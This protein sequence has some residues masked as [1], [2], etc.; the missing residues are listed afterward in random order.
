MHFVN[1]SATYWLGDCSAVYQLGFQDPATTT[2][3]GMCGKVC[4]FFVY[5]ALGLDV[6]NYL[7]HVESHCF[8]ELVAVDFLNPYRRARL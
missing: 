4:L 6:V 5:F 3:E 8:V 7:S 1:F 2:M